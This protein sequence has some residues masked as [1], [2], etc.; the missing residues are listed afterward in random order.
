[1]LPGNRS[2]IGQ[3]R[4]TPPSAAAALI[5]SSR[6]HTWFRRPRRSHRSLRSRRWDDRRWIRA[7]RA[8]LW[9]L[10]LSAWAAWPSGFVSDV[11]Q[12]MR[13]QGES[14]DCCCPWMP[15]PNGFG[16]SI[17][18]RHFPD[19]RRGKILPAC[20]RAPDAATSPVDWTQRFRQ[21]Q[22][23]WSSAAEPVKCPFFWR[24]ANGGWWPPTCPELRWNW[25]PRPRGKW[26][27]RAY[28]LSRRTCASLACNLNP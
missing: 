21:A 28:S 6:A 5:F 23:C 8:A 3:W 17:R 27:S 9:W 20:E 14:H 25:P 15:G 24:V 12:D 2:S 13:A 10:V 19:I 26:E 16:A 1:M 4:V 11:E 22:P 7:S 18:C